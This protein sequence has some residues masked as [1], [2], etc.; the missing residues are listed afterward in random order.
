MPPSF[1]KVVLA[2]LLAGSPRRIKKGLQSSYAGSFPVLLKPEKTKATVVLPAWR[3]YIL[4]VAPS[5]RCWR[6]R[7]A[8]TSGRSICRIDCRRSCVWVAFRIRQMRKP[9]TGEGS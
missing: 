1:I 8:D 5:E 6:C 7:P 2:M 9:R 3:W 4:P